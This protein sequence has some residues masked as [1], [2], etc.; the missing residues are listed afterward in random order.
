MPQLR[1]EL[2]LDP[3]YAQPPIGG[4]RFT[5]PNLMPKGTLLELTTRPPL[6]LLRYALNPL[7]SFCHL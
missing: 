6:G 3:F 2:L 5:S 7:P 4:L 1:C